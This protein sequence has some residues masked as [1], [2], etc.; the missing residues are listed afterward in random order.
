MKR[1]Q[2]VKKILPVSAALVISFQCV[3]GTS[4]TAN[5]KSDLEAKQQEL[6]NELSNVN[7]KLSE[8]EN[9]AEEA[10]DYMNKYD[11][12]MKLQEQQVAV[13][14]EQ[15]QLCSE[16]I[17]G[18][19]ED[20]ADKEEELDG[21]IEQFRQRLRALYMAGNDSLASVIAGSNDFYDMLARM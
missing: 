13:V 19:E 1:K 9:L 3:L 10:E 18:L 11:E 15:I 20:I 4:V 5:T 8:Y 21:D 17:A 16:E 6:E 12:K 14:E 2:F 7:S